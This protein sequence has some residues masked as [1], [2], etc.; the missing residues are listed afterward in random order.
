LVAPDR[1]AQIHGAGIRGRAHHATD[2]A[3][4]EGAHGRIARHGSYRGAACPADQGS[5]GQTIALVGAATGKDQSN[6]K[7]GNGQHGTHGTLLMTG[8]VTLSDGGCSWFPA[9]PAGTFHPCQGFAPAART[10]GPQTDH[11]MAG[12]RHR[13]R[14][15]YLPAEEFSRV[16]KRM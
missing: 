13:R 10:H 3:A 2:K 7:S 6:C 16:L 12:N 5:A 9:S 8:E 14:V 11:L 1:S 4:S 15:I